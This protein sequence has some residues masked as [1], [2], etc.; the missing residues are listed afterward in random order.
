[1]PSA[2]PP[3]SSPRRTSGH[4]TYTRPHGKVTAQMPQLQEGCQSPDSE[5]CGIKD[6]GSRYSAYSGERGREKWGKEG[7]E[8]GGKGGRRVRL[9]CSSAVLDPQPCLSHEFPTGVLWNTV[10]QLLRVCAGLWCGCGCALCIRTLCTMCVM[11]DNRKAQDLPLRCRV[12]P[13]AQQQPHRT[14][15]CAPAP[16]YFQQCLNTALPA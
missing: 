10:S 1:M 3:H 14:W 11:C 6:W 13:T 9:S 16:A 8:R 4:P 12:K 2:G 7:Q 5:L 15:G